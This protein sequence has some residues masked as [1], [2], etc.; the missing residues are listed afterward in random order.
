MHRFV[1]NN[2]T[3]RSMTV[4]WTW[5]IKTTVVIVLFCDYDDPIQYYLVY[6]LQ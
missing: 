1:R 5:I 6:Y 2:K 4:Y 3:F